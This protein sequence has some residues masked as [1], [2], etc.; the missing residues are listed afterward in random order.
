MKKS[1]FLGMNGNWVADDKPFAIILK[2][3]LH[4]CQVSKV[5]STI[6]LII[7]TNWTSGGRNTQVDARQDSFFTL[8]S[9]LQ[10]WTRYVPNDDDRLLPFFPASVLFSSLILWYDSCCTTCVRK[11]PRK[12]TQGVLVVRLRSRSWRYSCQLSSSDMSCASWLNRLQG[13]KKNGNHYKT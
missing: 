9:S 2:L 8:S 12:G 7:W 6:V 10:P 4:Y 5:L 1:A 11:R 13:R 3:M